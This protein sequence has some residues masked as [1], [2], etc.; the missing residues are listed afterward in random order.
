MLSGIKMQY[1]SIRVQITEAE[2]DTLRT[3]GENYGCIY[4]GKFSISR[5]LSKIASGELNITRKNYHYSIK[6]DIPLIELTIEVLSDLNG[7]IY[8]ISETIGISQGNIFGIKAK[9]HENKINIS[10]SLPKNCDLHKLFDDL[11]K[12]SINDVVEYNTLEKIEELISKMSPETKNYYDRLEKGSSDAL[13]VKDKFL[14]DFGEQKLV[15]HI[16]CSFGFEI[17]VKNKPGNLG[18]LT[19]VISDNKISIASIEQ[20]IDP[21]SSKYNLAKIFL[22]FVPS[23]KNYSVQDEIK[24]IEKFIDNLNKLDYI[25]GVKRISIDYIKSN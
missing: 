1:K 2:N 22:G 9:D 10:L 15:S 19:R 14:Y 17:R 12:I 13:K 18:K 6:Q 4:R 25:S 7:T 23:N 3:I 21:N 8:K 24:S 5:L 20:E 16:Y 11:S